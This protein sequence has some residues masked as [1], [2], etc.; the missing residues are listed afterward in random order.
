MMIKKENGFNRKK[1]VYSRDGEDFVLT[2]ILTF[3]KA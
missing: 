3:K 2:T 1:E